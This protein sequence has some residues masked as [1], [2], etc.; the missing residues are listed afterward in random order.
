MI[1]FNS[2]LDEKYGYAFSGEDTYVV[3]KAT[4]MAICANPDDEKLVK[5]IAAAVI[6]DDIYGDMVIFTEEQSP[7]CNCDSCCGN[8][9]KEA[10][11]LEE[12]QDP[13]GVEAFNAQLNAIDFGEYLIVIG[14]YSEKDFDVFVGTKAQLNEHINELRLHKMPRVYKMQELKVK[15]KY[16]V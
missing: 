7:E 2:S 12:V 13:E 1:V 3:E 9:K 4:G 8:C 15:V 11:D 14:D 5:D 6:K 16:E 10:E